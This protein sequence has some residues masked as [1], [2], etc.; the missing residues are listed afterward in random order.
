MDAC[1]NERL[2]EQGIEVPG[3]IPRTIL[4]CFFPNDTDSSARRQ[5]R[6]DAVFVRSTPGRSHHLDSTKIPPQDRNIHL[7]EFRLCPDTKPSS[8]LEAATTQHA[9][10]LIR[11]KTH[12]SRNP[13]RNNK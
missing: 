9:N 12:S 1:R 2:L 13:N 5:S 3:N 7:V 6:P 11:L 10:T 8:T 4:D